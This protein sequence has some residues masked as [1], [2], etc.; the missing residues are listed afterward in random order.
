M[1][2]GAVLV[3]RR[4]AIPGRVDGFAELLIRLLVVVVAIVIDQAQP[5]CGLLDQFR[6]C[7]PLLDAAPDGKD[8][9]GHHEVTSWTR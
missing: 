9:P 3:V 8:P 6:H 1:L 2:H 4:G 5:G 7:R